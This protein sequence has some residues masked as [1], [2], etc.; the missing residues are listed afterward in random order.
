MWFGTFSTVCMRLKQLDTL[1]PAAADN[2]LLS[3]RLI[4]HSFKAS[5]CVCVC[6]YVCTYACVCAPAHTCPCIPVQ[7]P[8][9]RHIYLF[10]CR[11]WRSGEA[12]CPASFLIVSLSLSLLPSLSVSPSLSQMTL[13]AESTVFA[14]PASSSSNSSTS[15]AANAFLPPVHD[16]RSYTTAAVTVAASPPDD[17]CCMSASDPQMSNI[18]FNDPFLSLSLPLW[19]LVRGKIRP[20]QNKTL[21][22]CCCSAPHCC[23]HVCCSLMVFFPKRKKIFLFHRPPHL[24][25]STTHI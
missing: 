17:A 8:R 11:R 10:V 7:S 12:K 3:H 20:F 24:S 15:I 25:C 16:S 19:R 14:G 6:V 21:T 1:K 4:F 13:P 9:L 23:P 5:L 18:A 22:R 2:L